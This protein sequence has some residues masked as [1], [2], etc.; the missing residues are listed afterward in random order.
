MNKHHLNNSLLQTLAY[1]DIFDSPLTLSQLHTYLYKY[2]IDR[3]KLAQHVANVPF[4]KKIGKYYVFA[5]REK[6]VSQQLAKARESKRKMQI[7]KQ[8][9]RVLSHIPTIQLLGV[10]GSV[11]VESASK[12][13]DIDFFIVT[14]KN[15][16]WVTRFIVTGVLLVMKR[17]RMPNT[18]FS[19][20]SICTN[21][22][23]S[24]ASLMLPKQSLFHAREI[25]QLHVLVNR[26]NTM[27]KFVQANAW[28][29]EYFPNFTPVAGRDQRKNTVLDVF[30]K[31]INF[32]LFILQRWYMKRR[33]TKEVVTKNFAAFHPRDVSEIVMEVYDQRLKVY[34]KLFGQSGVGK[35]SDKDKMEIHDSYSITPGS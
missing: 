35:K 15:S 12:N 5:S 16:L 20:D 31:G 34:K 19:P 26:N 33:Q 10:S 11:A 32:Y 13:A 7:A 28:V 3:R 23:M 24:D 17:K 25:A 6:I 9:A 29:Q 21:M 1:S 18:S 22:W 4:I 30:V 27:Q 8:V 14:S 2:V